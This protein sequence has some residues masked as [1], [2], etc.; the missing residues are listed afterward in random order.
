VPPRKST[1][2]YKT[3]ALFKPTRWPTWTLVDEEEAAAADGDEEHE[4]V[5]PE[6]VE[7]SARPVEGQRNAAADTVLRLVQRATSALV[8]GI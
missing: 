5:N 1:P 8:R 3:Q 7:A 6:T 4:E 2:S